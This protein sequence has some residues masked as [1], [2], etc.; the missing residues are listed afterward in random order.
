[1]D[2]GRTPVCSPAPLG[3]EVNKTGLFCERGFGR[4]VGDGGDETVNRDGA[5]EDHPGAHRLLAHEVTDVESPPQ[6]SLS[7]QGG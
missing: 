3:K 4:T 7:M 1:M 5:V 2:D 6:V